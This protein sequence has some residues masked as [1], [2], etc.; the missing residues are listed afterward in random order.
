[1]PSARKRSVAD[2]ETLDALRATLRGGGLVHGVLAGKDGALGEP[3]ALRQVTQGW[4]V[5]HGAAAQADVEVTG[6]RLLAERPDADG[7]PVMAEI[8][9]PSPVPVPA[10]GPLAVVLHDRPG[11]VS[12]AGADPAEAALARPDEPPPAPVETTGI[13]SADPADRRARAG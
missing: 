11:F 12:D 2:Q 4:V 6:V 1:M 3:V 7:K 10:G 8:A 5:A 13:G 9:L